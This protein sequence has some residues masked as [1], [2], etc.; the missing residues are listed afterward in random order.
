MKDFSQWLNSQLEQSNKSQSDIAKGIGISKQQLTNLKRPGSNPRFNTFLKIRR[1]F[2]TKEIVL[3]ALIALM[4]VNYA[5][6]GIK[7]SNSIESNWDWYL[8]SNT[9]ELVYCSNDGGVLICL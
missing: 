3:I 9:S 6:T 4:S 1:Y 8:D 2:N 5:C 7:S